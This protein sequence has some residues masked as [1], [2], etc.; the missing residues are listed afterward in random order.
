[1]RRRSF[2]TLLGGAATWQYSIRFTARS[3]KIMMRGE[4]CCA[5][6]R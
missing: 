3:S 4:L 2:I 6:Q 5:T 1:M